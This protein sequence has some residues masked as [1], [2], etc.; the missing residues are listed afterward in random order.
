MNIEISVLTRAT[1]E[2]MNSEDLLNPDYVTYSFKI[3]KNDLI[4]DYESYSDNERTTQI[5]NLLDNHLVGD[6]RNISFAI[7][8]EHALNTELENYKANP[9]EYK[10]RE[11][12]VVIMQ[13]PKQT[14]TDKS[15]VED[16]G[17]Q[18]NNIVQKQLEKELRKGGTLSK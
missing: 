16:L 12:F 7:D 3:S 10:D 13:L 11:E 5:K 17:K 2:G 18:I 8:L 1:L 9:E 14:N 6:K 15:K 4:N